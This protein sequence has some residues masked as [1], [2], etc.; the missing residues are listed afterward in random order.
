MADFLTFNRFIASYVLI[1]IYYFLAIGIP[2][3][4]I[5]S[6]N[7]FIN[8]FSFLKHFESRV[9]EIFANSSLKQKFILTLAILA[10]ILCFEL[11]LRIFFE[12]LIGYFDIHN[13]LKERVWR[14]T[15]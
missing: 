7:K 3:F 10:I 13:F 1:V 8:Y 2:I 12:M 14:V 6:Y 5:I 11:F 9:K 15:V 4:A